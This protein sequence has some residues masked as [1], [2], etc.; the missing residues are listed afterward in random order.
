MVGSSPGGSELP[1]GN[2]FEDISPKELYIAR[3]FVPS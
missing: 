1:S 3:T 2:Q